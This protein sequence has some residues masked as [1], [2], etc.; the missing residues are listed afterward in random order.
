MG[1]VRRDSPGRDRQASKGAPRG[2]AEAL[3][4]KRDWTATWNLLGMTVSGFGVGWLVGQSVSPVVQGVITALVGI[5]TSMACLSRE[6][7][8]SAVA[9]NV[10]G[11]EPPKPTE[12]KPPRVSPV[13]TGCLAFGL[14]LGTAFGVAA[15]TH[16]WLAPKAEAAALQPTPKEKV[17]QWKLTGLDEKEI[18]KRL[19][20]RELADEHK[21][22]V[23][24]EPKEQPHRIPALFQ[25][26]V[27]P[28]E[29]ETFRT[30]DDSRLAQEMKASQNPRVRRFAEK[31]EKQPACLRAAVE[32]LIWPEP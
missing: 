17:E 11:D 29:Y 1:K 3:A 28:K 19:F 6:T 30:V 26:G 20:E 12:P 31:C 25:G 21:V 10:E 2:D 32:E 8:V 14:V 5:V 9:G 13:L 15:R 4:M 7:K 27:P 24:P 16:E 18:A 23:K 22:S